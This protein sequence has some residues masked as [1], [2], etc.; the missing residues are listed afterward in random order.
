MWQNPVLCTDL[1]LVIP[2]QRCDVVDGHI[3]VS[4]DTKNVSSYRAIY[5]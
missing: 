5:R 4:D 1:R 2:D 3:V